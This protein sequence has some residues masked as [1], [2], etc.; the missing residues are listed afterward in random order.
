VKALRALMQYAWPGNIRELEHEV[1]RL[2]Y[3]CPEGQA[4]DSSM[5]SPHIVAAPQAAGSETASRTLELAANVQAL[6]GRLI[7]EAL[8]KAGGN[9]TRAARLLG[10]SRNGLAIKMER[11]ALRD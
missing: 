10:I 8:A 6:E 4:I 9:R 11:L 5:V 1:R 2:M 7:R 3:L